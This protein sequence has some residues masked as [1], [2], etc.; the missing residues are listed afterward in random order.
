[1]KPIFRPWFRNQWL[2]VGIFLLDLGTLPLT[3]EWWELDLGT[4]HLAN[5]KIPL[6]LGVCLLAMVSCILVLVSF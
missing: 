2:V 6:V 3:L 4:W 1:M 5:E